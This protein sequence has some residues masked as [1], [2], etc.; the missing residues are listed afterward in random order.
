MKSSKKNKSLKILVPFDF[1]S[2]YGFFLKPDVFK[3]L[4]SRGAEIIPLL[5][6]EDLL[7][8]HLEDADGLLI[9]G[10]L[11]DVEPS[12]YGQTKKYECVKVTKERCDFEYKLIDKFLKTE[13]PLLAI[14]WGHQML[15]VFLNGS[16]HQDLPQD[17]PSDISHE[18]KEP[19]HQPTHWVEFIEGHETF[20][21]RNANRKLFVNST[22]HQAI[23]R[24]AK[25]LIAEAHSEDGLIEAYQMKGHA[26]A[27]GV[28]WH[29]ERL[30]DDPV[31]P[32]F[33]EFCR[34]R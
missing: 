33:L 8:K 7:K 31:I 26:F 29:P 21:P 6:D 32:K 12:L 22:H 11:G 3:A 27:W 30:A 16:L 5:Y 14:C 19:G 17:R 25:D 28:Q 10:G 34:K 9:P 13:K 15:N 1:D 24:L 20:I 4:R 23:D 2:K 18:Q